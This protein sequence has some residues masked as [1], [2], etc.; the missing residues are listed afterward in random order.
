MAVQDQYPGLEQVNVA[1]THMGTSLATN[2]EQLE[3][4]GKEVMPTFKV[5]AKAPAVAD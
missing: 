2:L 3:W 5:Q 4:F 1:F